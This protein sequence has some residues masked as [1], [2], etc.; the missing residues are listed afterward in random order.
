MKQIL[1]SYRT[2]HLELADVPAPCLEPGSV[3]VLTAASLLSV[4]TERMTMAL[5]KKSL[6]GKARAR[7]DLVRKVLE[8]LSRD[9]LLTTGKAVLNKLDQPIPL[10]YSCAGRVVAVGDGVSGIAVGDRVACAGAKVANHAEVN[11]VPKNLCARVP[12]GV[13]D[14]AA[15]F[16][17][18]GAIALQGVRTGKPTLGEAFAVIGLGLIGQLAAQILRANGC[19][20]LGIDLDPG[21]VKLARDL[22]AEEAVVRGG[23]VAQACA[24]LTDGRGVDGVLICAASSSNDPVALA[25]DLCRDRG[26]VAVVGAVR[27]EIPRRPYY[28][29]EI[30]FLQSRSYGPGRYDPVYEEAGVDYPAGYVRWTEQRNM[31]A[32][33]HLCARGA[34]QVT[35]LVTH[36]FDIER[37]EEAYALLEGGGEP[38]GIVLKYPARAVPPRS[39]TMVATRRAGAGAVRVGFIGA[40]AFAAGT[41]VPAVAKAGGTRL[42]AIASAR[43]FTAR[44]LAQRHNFE[45]C[46]TDA[47]AVATDPG[48]DAVFIA[49]R[50]NLHAEQ[51]SAAL[52]A[53]KHVFVEK[54][55][56]LTRDELDSVL[57][58]QRAAGTVLAVGYNRRYSPL[59]R[60][61]K[62]FFERRVAPLVMHYRVNAGAIPAD[63]WIHDPSIGGGRIIGEGC[64]FIDLCAYLAGGPPVSVYAQG[65]EPRA[66]ARVDDNVTLSL[67]FSDGSI[68]TIAYVATGD[69][70]SGK[71]HLEVLGDGAQAVLGDFRRLEL[72]R[73]GKRRLV[74]KFS[75]DKG[76]ATGVETFLEA[77]RVGG[78]QP[79]PLAVLAA[80]SMATFGAMES[81]A[82]GAPVDLTQVR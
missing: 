6:V 30:A 3:L 5:A 11:L 72:R 46:T 25:G 37:A 55:L 59:A 79:I 1:Q 17:T 68:A 12:E 39:V 13:G 75:Q 58:A 63:S 77:A 7:P 31:E 35:P 62:A 57:E 78:L 53:G 73:G 54:P 10:G 34:V 67:R 2:G 43:G 70:T 16:V 23:D 19:R 81:L 14:E 29:K 61:L 51:A 41:L 24:S 60:E 15:A 33:L 65:V 56:A 40:G 64:H 69:P 66:G 9:G 4:G 76:H 32:F 47:A 50:H 20:V 45:T 8:R 44:H 42:V 74:S 49:T 26:R 22:G 82:S 80:V 71:E 27:M 52:R 48:V 28:D 36:R 18:V 38:L 21:K